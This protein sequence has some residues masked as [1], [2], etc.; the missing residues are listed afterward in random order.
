VN[1][2][3][4]CGPTES[5]LTEEH[6]W[7]QW[8]SKLLLGKYGSDHF[9]HVRSTG[10]DTTG[11]WKAPVLKVTTKT[12]CD[13]CNNVWLSR[14]ENEVVKPIAG[15][16][17]LGEPVDLIKPADQ[18]QLSVWAYKMAILLEVAMP[19]EERSPEFFTASERLDFH[20][21]TYP[22]EH[23]RVF[24]S[25]YKETKMPAHAHQHQYAMTRRDDG[26]SYTLRIMTLTAGCLAMQVIALRSITNRSLA[27]ATS[28]MEVEFQGKTSR[29]VASIWPP[30]NQALRWCDLEP[31]T[32]QDI[33]DW[34]EM[35]SKAEGMH[36]AAPSPTGR[37]SSEPNAGAR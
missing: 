20:K 28:E 21:T 13:K 17:I 16:L 29:A 24:V 11:Y 8:V 1:E 14:L 9:I 22:N 36:S 34:T 23:V 37:C 19:K 4:F 30:T 15:P 25:N 32:Q 6:V 3:F 7:P 26:V 12:L 18:I 5:P 31:M 27:Y 2:C 33:E 10:N 35:W